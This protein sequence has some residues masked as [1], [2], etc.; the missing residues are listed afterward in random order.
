[1]FKCGILDL[2]G[3]YRLSLSGSVTQV[4]NPFKRCSIAGAAGALL[5]CSRGWR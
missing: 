5:I 2:V 4:A 3:S 1:M